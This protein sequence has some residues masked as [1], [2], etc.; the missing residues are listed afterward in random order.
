MRYLII[1]L[2]VLGA[3]S[4]VLHTQQPLGNRGELKEKLGLTDEQ[5]ETLREIRMNTA[6][7]MIDIRAS[8]AKKRLDLKAQMSDDAP[9]RQAVQS[10]MSDMGALKIQRNMLLFDTRTAMLKALTPEQQKQFKELRRERGHQMQK[11]MKNRMKYRRPGMRDGYRGGD[12]PGP[13]MGF[14]DEQSSQ[15]GIE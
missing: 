13:P 2:L 7:Q 1:A 6:K 11:G 3:T 15:T 4:P 8:I 14:I 5:A 12:T 9:D 10:L